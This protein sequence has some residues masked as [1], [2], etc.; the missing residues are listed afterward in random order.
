M[1]AIV[2]LRQLALV[3]GGFVAISDG[4]NGNVFRMKLRIGFE[5]HY[6][7]PQPTPMM[8]ML[9]IHHSRASDIVSSPRKT[10]MNK[11]EG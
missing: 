1:H 8:L 10:T 2:R 7:F 3:S 4:A 11:D 6:E 9:N 5:M